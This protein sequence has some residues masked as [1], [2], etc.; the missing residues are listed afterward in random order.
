MKVNRGKV[1]NYLGIK[2]D[3]IKLGKV[4]IT[5]LNYIDEIID[6]FDKEDTTCGGTKSSAAPAVLF[7]PNKDCEK[8]NAKKV[9]EFHHRLAKKLFVTKRARP[10]TCT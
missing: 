5:M 6:A 4:K 7:K 10:Y 1:H 2:L 9:V 8:I 3:Y